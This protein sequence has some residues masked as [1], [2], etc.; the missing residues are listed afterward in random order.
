[1]RMRPGNRAMNSLNDFLDDRVRRFGSLPALSHRPRY[2]TVQWRFADLGRQTTELADAL[3]QA[4]IGPGDR[5]LLQAGNSPYWV[6][7]FFAVA[8]C[9]G[10][11]V[12]ANPRSPESHLRRIINDASPRLT[13]RSSLGQAGASGLPEWVLEDA[14]VR[15]GLISAPLH[16]EE[17]LPEGLAEILYTSGTTGVPKGV[18]LTPTNLLS[19][20]AG[21]SQAVPLTPDDH[22]LNLVP[23][24]HAYGQT[25]AMLC[26]LSDGCP[27]SHVVQ[28][29]A[30]AIQEALARV[31][32]THLILV[33]EILKTLME[34]LE[35]RLGRWPGFM[36]R[37]FR[38]R[39]RHRLSPTLRT[40]CCGGAPLDPRL[41]E[42]W[43]EL[44][45][46]VLQGY[47]LTE[48]SP[49][50]TANTP[51][52]HRL[53]SVGRPLAGVEL[54]LADDGEVQARG[55]MVMAGYFRQPE[56]TSRTVV[57]GWFRT[58][59]MGW[60]DDQGF[61]YLQGRRKYLIIGPGGENVFPEDIETEIIHQPGVSDAT[62]IGLERAG[63]TVIQAVLIARPEL[64]A[65]AVASANRALASHQQIT[66]WSLWP[67]G[68]FPRSETHKVRK[69][70]VLAWLQGQRNPPMPGPHMTDPKLLPLRSVLAE[71]SGVPLESIGDETRVISGLAVDSLLRLELTT[72]LEDE[73]GLCI[74]ETEITP[75]LTV[76]G[77]GARLGQRR[78]LVG[79][80]DYPR[81]FQKPW[82]G[83]L[84]PW[85]SG[86]LLKTWV[87]WCCRLRVDGLEH[88]DLLTGPCLF[89]ANHRSYLDSAA[90]VL[91]LPEAFQQ[92]LGIAAAT[93]VLYRRY[94]WAAPL[95]ELTL[96]A[97]PLPTGLHENIQSGFNTMGRLLDDGW[98]VL[99]F[100]EGRMNRVDGSLQPLRA[101]TGLLAV[102]MGVPVVPV[103]IIGTERV[104]PPERIWPRAR[105]HVTVRL[106]SPLSF[107]DQ[108]P[109]ATA[110]DRIETAMRRL[111]APG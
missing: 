73:L 77:L 76:A 24:F 27:V 62:V 42:R 49:V 46:E 5:V 111:L 55:P 2:R 12:P 63:R 44:G 65:Q 81:N 39:I 6:A 26:P 32:A 79:A 41:E 45:F 9:G 13:L 107:A 71:L 21:L 103:A 40:I 59:D 8:R 72:R 1:M 53:G 47:G 52:A 29:T 84:R 33:P 70:Q 50:I 54:R 60:L 68:D 89:F 56:L 86:L 37:L 75:D 64:A 23:L 11:L 106:G 28:P 88:L 78:S 69:E 18:M 92:R 83:R 98:S 14:A 105:G 101:G 7:A 99:L 82:A 4:G 30:R 109:H 51:T 108:T 102:K 61:L 22:V 74:D 10:V 17:R 36:T 35:Q 3:W 66:D 19:D 93:E 96:N 95:A 38:D 57:D 48:T 15:P 20:M 16:D 58:G 43:R 31:R 90:L 110:R 100:P 34:R 91:S 25:A 85:L 104:L 80:T 67:D 87:P 94:A 97:F